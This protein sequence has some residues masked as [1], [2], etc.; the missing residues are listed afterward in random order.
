[1]RPF[2]GGCQFKSNCQHEHE[3]GCAIRKAVMAGKITAHRYESYVK[4]LHE[5]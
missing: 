2:I 4:L 5:E 3:P 1:M